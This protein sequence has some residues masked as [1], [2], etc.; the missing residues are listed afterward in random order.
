MS[1]DTTTAYPSMRKK[2]HFGDCLVAT[3]DL[4]IGVIVQKFLAEPTE[5][6]FHGYLTAPLEERHVIIIGKDAFGAYQYGRVI[7]DAKFINHSCNPNCAV[8]EKDGK[9]V[10]TIRSVREN[11][12][13]TMGYDVGSGYWDPRWNFNCLCLAA[14]CRKVINGFK[15]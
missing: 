10:K 3:K 8:D 7:S 11:E 9:V 12:E 13:L 14:N 5:K 15:T 6:I 2:N 4:D 1:I